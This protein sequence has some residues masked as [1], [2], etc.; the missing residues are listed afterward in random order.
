D[1]A[2]LNPNVTLGQRGYT[3]YLEYPTVPYSLCTITM[4]V[5]AIG[6]SPPYYVPIGWQATGFSTTSP[7]VTQE[8]YIINATGTYSI[9]VYSTDVTTA[10][11]A[12]SFTGG[13]A[14]SGVT[15]TATN[16]SAAILG[17]SNPGGFDTND[18]YLQQIASTCYAYHPLGTQF[19]AASIG[20]TVFTVN[21][22]YAG[23][24]YNVTLNPFQTE[25]VSCNLLLIYN[26]DPF[27]AGFSNGVFDISQLPTLATQIQE[28]INQYFLSKTLPTDLVYTI[29]ELSE[30]IQNAYTGIV[31]LIGNSSTIFSFG[32]FNPTTTGLVYL[33]RPIGYNYVLSINNFNFTAKDKDLL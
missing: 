4:T 23:Y 33:R 27:D 19:Y 3:V 26:S 11:P 1:P 24:T 14:I 21:T 18:L 5:S 32:T 6:G 13:S 30:L 9:N 2:I 7:Y 12:S 16:Q 25:Q 8:S 28:L 29:N 31:A 22:P 20:S 15:F 10:V 17:G